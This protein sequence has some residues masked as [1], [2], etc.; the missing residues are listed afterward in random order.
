MGGVIMTKRRDRVT[1][2]PL[3]FINEMRGQIQTTWTSHLYKYKGWSMSHYGIR[4]GQNPNQGDLNFEVVHIPLWFQNGVW[5]PATKKY[6]NPQQE[7]IQ[8]LL[9]LAATAAC[10]NS[11]NYRSIYLTFR[12]SLTRMSLLLTQ[13][14]AL[15]LVNATSGHFRT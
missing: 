5:P 14:L 15:F 9:D 11:L 12:I 8:L 7:K 2:L 1:L 6:K 3:S 4:M 10:N 13:S